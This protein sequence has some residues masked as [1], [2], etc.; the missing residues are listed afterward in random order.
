MY[1]VAP[2]TAVQVK[3]TERTSTA[4]QDN[5]VGAMV[6]VFIVLPAIGTVSVNAAQLADGDTAAVTPSS[7]APAAA[8]VGRAATTRISSPAARR[9][10]VPATRSRASAGPAAGP[11]DRR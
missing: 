7:S 2:G 6:G 11:V 3:V 10:A 4:P 1:V 8:R 9:G 5:V